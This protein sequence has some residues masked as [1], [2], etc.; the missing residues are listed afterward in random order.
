MGRIIYDDYNGN[1]PQCQTIMGAVTT[2]WGHIALRN[3]W[4][5]IEWDEDESDGGERASVHACP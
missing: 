2:T 4:K 3:G 1:V 5:L